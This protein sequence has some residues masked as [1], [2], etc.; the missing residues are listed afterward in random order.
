MLH[1]EY[2]MVEMKLYADFTTMRIEMHFFRLFFFL[3]QTKQNQ[4]LRPNSMPVTSVH[5]QCALC[6]AF[7]RFL[8]QKQRIWV[9]NWC[10]ATF[11]PK[12]V[13]HDREIHQ[14]Q[15]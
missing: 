6:I 10:S 11:G 12:C 2:K 7:E 1:S 8:Y 5:V 3:F 13:L 14:Q 15:L 9:K 4:E